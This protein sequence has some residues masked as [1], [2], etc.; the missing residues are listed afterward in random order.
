MP[1]DWRNAAVCIVTDASS[2][3]STA[4]CVMIVNE[5]IAWAREFLHHMEFFD[6]QTPDDLYKLFIFCHVFSWG[7]ILWKIRNYW[8]SFCSNYLLINKIYCFYLSFIGWT[9]SSFDSL[10]LLRS[11]SSLKIS[12]RE[13]FFGKD[14]GKIVLGLLL[15]GWLGCDTLEYIDIAWNKKGEIYSSFSVYKQSHTTMLFKFKIL[16]AN[17]RHMCHLHHIT[18]ADSSLLH[19]CLSAVKFVIRSCMAYV[20]IKLATRSWFTNF[21]Q[22]NFLHVYVN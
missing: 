13:S 18:S 8:Y 21:H 20:H 3:V 11:S 6:V 14:F 12:A 9:L 7:I 15:G 19:N 5:Y 2:I 17:C 1:L 4:S 10:C 16:W 22:N